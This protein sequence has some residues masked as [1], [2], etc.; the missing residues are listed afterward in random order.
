VHFDD[1]LSAYADTHFRGEVSDP[2]LVEGLTE[3]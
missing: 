1:D 2:Y 3:T